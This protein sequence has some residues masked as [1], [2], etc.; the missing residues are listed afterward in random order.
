MTAKLMTVDE[1]QAAVVD[2]ALAI[3]EHAHSTDPFEVSAMLWGAGNHAPLDRHDRALARR[4]RRMLDD[5][6]NLGYAGIIVDQLDG[7][8]S[9][10]ALDTGRFERFSRPTS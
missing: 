6:I 4:H 8:A 1:A 7:I 9:A 2:T 5:I 3:V 10:A